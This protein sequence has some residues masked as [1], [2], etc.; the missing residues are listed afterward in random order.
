M[1]IIACC[2]ASRP[3]FAEEKKVDPTATAVAVDAF[4]LMG[5]A[6]KEATIFRVCSAV[7]PDRKDLFDR[8]FADLRLANGQIISMARDKA[9]AI[10]DLYASKTDYAKTKTLIDEIPKIALD[11]VNKMIQGSSS[12]RAFCEAAASTTSVELGLYN[13]EREKVEHVFSFVVGYSWKLPTCEYN[14]IFRVRPVVE[15]ITTDSGVQNYRAMT[16]EAAENPVIR[17]SCWEMTKSKQEVIRLLKQSGERQAR[18]FGVRDVRWREGETPK[19]Y[20]LVAAGSKV[21]AGISISMVTTILLGNHSVL[22]VLIVEP[23]DQYPSLQSTQ[24]LDWIERH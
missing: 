2:A 6:F 3:A 7:I 21:A 10:A 24:F 14:V 23:A 5:K 15:T 19:G 1:S 11:E 17:V 13:E 16:P 18:D 9:L 4:V 12:P 20:Q 22:E 8:K